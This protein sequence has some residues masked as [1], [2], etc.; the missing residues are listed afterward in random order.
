M[1][2]VSVKTVQIICKMTNTFLKFAGVAAVAL[3]L[4]GAGLL[5]KQFAA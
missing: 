5:R 3:A 2:M 4:S 1:E